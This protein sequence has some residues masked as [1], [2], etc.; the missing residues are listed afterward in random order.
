MGDYA[1]IVP[2]PFNVDDEDSI[3]RVM[4]E[5]DV[6]INLIG[7]DYETTHY[8]PWMVNSSF[9]KTHIDVPAKLARL[10][11]EEGVTNFVHVSA[12]GSD[13]YS[14]SRWSRAKAAGE[15]A[16]RAEA[17][18]ATIVRPADVFGPEDRLLNLYAKM[19]QVFPRVPLV[20]GGVARTQPVYVNDV[21]DAIAK[22]ALSTDP[23]V[24]L[25]QTYDVAG[26]EVYSYR[27]IV[28]YVF[29]SI[30]A[31]QPSVTNL[32]PAIADIV[33]TVSDVFPNPLINR[34][35]FLRM[36]SDVVLDD[37]AP[38]KRLHDLGIEATSM[39]SPNFTFLHR[40]RSGSH[41]LDIQEGKTH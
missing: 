6:V 34:D 35:R 33:G 3:R 4:K 16:V 27:E 8:M 13:P 39:E 17:P 23:E 9:E 2:V 26:P 5:S 28:E 37:M 25:G 11:V 19:Y 30:R 40:Y 20:D 38:T 41:F 36:Q 12:L 24:M 10:A 18:G 29:E 21:A 15:E 1:M 14:I 7:K 31:T 32:S 22:I